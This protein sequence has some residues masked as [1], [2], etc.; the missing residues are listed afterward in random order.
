MDDK[1]EQLHNTMADSE[2]YKLPAEKINQITEEEKQLKIQLENAY[3]H[4]E[5]LEQIQD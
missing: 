3:Q 1:I 5:E 2:F 4:W